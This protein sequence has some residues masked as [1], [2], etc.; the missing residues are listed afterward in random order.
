MGEII[1][2]GT[3]ECGGR[4]YTEIERPWSFFQ[5]RVCLTTIDTEWQLAQQEFARVGLTVDKFQSL[6]DIGPHQS[7]SKSEREILL[8]FWQSEAETLLHLEDDVQFRNL[9][10]LEAAIS[11]LPAEWDILYLGANLICW[12][13]DEP[14]PERVS[15]HLWRVR[16]AWTTHAV[17]YHRKCVFEV[18][19]KQPCFSE[20]MFDNWLSTRLP[21]L[22][23]YCVGPM[24]AWQRP[25]VSSIWQRD[26]VDDYTGIFEASEGRLR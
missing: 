25:H 21:E 22:N 10:H 8:G 17:A 1:Y 23:A 3:D 11:E 26:Y 15:E 16:A 9:G 19:A 18:I 13:K 7:F 2:P 14:Q 4:L 12:N 5:R 6:P 24:A 20:I